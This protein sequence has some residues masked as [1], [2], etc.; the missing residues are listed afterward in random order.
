MTTQ[1]QDD[2]SNVGLSEAA[3]QLC[4]RLKE[5][6]IF[7]ELLDVYRLG[8]A[9]SIKSGNAAP[10]ISRQRNMFNVG[11][12]DPDG[13]IRDL[14]MELYPEHAERPYAFAEQ[15]AEYGVTEIG[16]LHESGQLR[17]RNLLATEVPAPGDEGPD[18]AAP[19]PSAIGETGPDGGTQQ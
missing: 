12:L 1:T 7:K 11:S 8:I 3:Y 4:S 16:R 10:R 5:D 14:I 6:G 13:T 19:A 9:L 2:R 15:L 18:G 17:F